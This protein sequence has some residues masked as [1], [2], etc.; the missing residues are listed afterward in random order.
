MQHVEYSWQGQRGQKVYAQEWQPEGRPRA[1]VALVH[2]LGE[3]SGRYQHVAAH[4]NRAGYALVGF[5]LPGHGRTEGK[6]GH[7]SFQEAMAEIDCLLEKTSEHFPGAP[8]FLY[9]HSMGGALVLNYLLIRQSPIRGAIVTSPGLGVSVPA[10]KLSLAKI[11]AGI[12]PAFTL[13]N[14]LDRKNLSCDPAVIEAYSKDPLV[15]DRAS[16][17]LGRD[18]ITRGAWIIAHASEFPFPLLLMQGSEDHIVSLEATQAFAKGVPPE[19]ITF[20]VWEGLCHECHNEPEQD[21]VI[22]TMVDWLDLHL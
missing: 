11:L 17:L 6:R 10:W 2:G 5:D 9:G 13:S 7:T 19:K 4:F 20:K 21:Q 18:V 1:A 22:Q 14:G 16:A 3:H 12:L 8:L 15:H